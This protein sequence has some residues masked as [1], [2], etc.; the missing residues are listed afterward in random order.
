MRCLRCN[1]TMVNEFPSKD[2]LLRAGKTLL[3]MFNPV[4]MVTTA[5]FDISYKNNL[6]NTKKEYWCPKC[7]LFAIQCPYCNKIGYTKNSIPNDGKK[8][9]TQCYKDFYYSVSE[10]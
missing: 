10:D 7:N 1:N 8:T 4:K 9:C 6:L 5:L 2:I 3:Q